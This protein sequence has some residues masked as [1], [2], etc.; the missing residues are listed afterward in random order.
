MEDGPWYSS[1]PEAGSES[2]SGGGKDEVTEY[3]AVFVVWCCFEL[4]G[5]GMWWGETRS[6]VQELE[7]GT[8]TLFLL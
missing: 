2:V 7:N 4:Y 5:V 8:L 1:L 6:G 3:L